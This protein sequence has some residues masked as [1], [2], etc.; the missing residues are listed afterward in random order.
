VVDDE[1]GEYVFRALRSVAAGE[2]VSWDYETF[3]SEL[4]NPF[5][6]R[7]GASNCRRL[8]TGRVG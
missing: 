2:E 7:C 6:C 5:E 1:R 3:E 8:I 4:S